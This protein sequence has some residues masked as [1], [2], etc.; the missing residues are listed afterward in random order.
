M[1]C[2]TVATDPS[3]PALSLLGCPKQFGFIIMPVTDAIRYKFVCCCCARMN[4]EMENNIRGPWREFAK[5]GHH[6]F[7]TVPR[8]RIAVVCPCSA[9][10]YI[11][12]GRISHLTF[13]T[14]ELKRVISFRSPVPFVRPFCSEL[15][16]FGEWV[17]LEEWANDNL[18]TT[19]V[20]GRFWWLSKKRRGGK[21]FRV[22]MK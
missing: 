12:W 3:D 1:G 13:R 16:V 8:P 2:G 22:E 21:E 17:G 11:N 4:D 10:A 15:V 20:E 9:R 7:H 19:F 18:N 5:Y 6:S 14:N